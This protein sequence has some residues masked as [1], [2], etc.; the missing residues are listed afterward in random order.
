M[1][2]EC[3]DGM[4]GKPHIGGDDKGRLHAGIAGEGS[5]VLGTGK[6]FA[7]TKDGSNRV[8][9]GTGDALI[10]GRHVSVTESEQVT[11]ESGTQGQKRNDLICLQYHREPSSGVESAKLTVLK[12]APN[13]STAAD[14]SVPG[15]NVLNGAADDYM[16]LYRVALDGVDM[17]E[18]VALFETVPAL[19]DLKEAAQPKILYESQ[20]WTVWAVGKL[21][22]ANCRMVVTE[23]GAWASVTCPY[24]IPSEYR[25]HRE[26]SAPLVTTNGGS[27]TGAVT[28]NPNGSIAAKNL[29]NAG[30][31]DTR[32]GSITWVAG[33]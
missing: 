20:Y 31:R 11:I 33:H 3:I 16:P 2:V 19:T 6:R 30:S 5:Y 28:V 23:A 10:H 7:A 1:T 4:A 26:Y 21:C 12:G 13:P 32:N 24:T 8:T 17:A 9:I 22:G 18:P 25:P 29:G 15:G 14:P 27:W